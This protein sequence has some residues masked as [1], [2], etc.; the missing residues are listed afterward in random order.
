VNNFVALKIKRPV[1]GAIEQRD[2]FLLAINKTFD[3]VIIL[4]VFVPLRR[5]DADFGIAD[6]AQHF[7]RLVIARAKRDDEFV[8]DWQDRADGRNKRI[9]EPLA[10]A[11]KS[12]PA[13]FHAAILPRAALR[14]SAKI[15]GPG[16]VWPA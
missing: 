6:V 16:G 5:D 12:E 13:D 7:F 14:C 8:H 1:A 11:K 2:G 15:N 10:V 9:A 4:D 3:A